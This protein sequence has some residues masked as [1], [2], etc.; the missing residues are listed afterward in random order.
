MATPH[1]TARPPPPT[2][3][4]LHP[5][6]PSCISSSSCSSSSSS[7]HLISGANWRYPVLAGQAI[8]SAL[9]R[10]NLRLR[11][12]AQIISARIYGCPNVRIYLNSA[13]RSSVGFVGLRRCHRHHRRRRRCHRVTNLGARWLYCWSC[14]GVPQS[15]SPLSVLPRSPVGQPSMCPSRFFW[16]AN[17]AFC[18][19][20]LIYLNVRQ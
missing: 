16:P 17:A 8:Q 6:H 4:P 14:S 20:V 11:G 13:G 5:I 19:A 18:E 15:T 12:N 9:I 10:R 2:P 1:Y 7:S 3:P